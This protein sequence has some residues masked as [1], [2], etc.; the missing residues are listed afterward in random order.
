MAAEGKRRI[1]VIGNG[2]IGHGIA[3]IFACG[4]WQVILVGRSKAS[5]AAALDKIAASL[6][7]F[8]THG[9]VNAAQKA[10]ALAVIAIMTSLDDAAPA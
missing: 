2:I 10:A 1:A 5:L 7:L 9:L 6:A 4:G 8:E 3:E